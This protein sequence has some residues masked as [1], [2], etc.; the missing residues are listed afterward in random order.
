MSDVTPIINAIDFIEAH[1]QKP[2]TVADVAEAASYSLYH[3]C[4]MFNQAT[5]HTPYDY[6]MRRRLSQAVQDL[7]QTDKKIIDVALEYQFNNPETFSRAFRRMF[8]APPTQ[9]RKEGYIDSRRLRHRLTL[10]HLEHLQKASHLRPTLETRDTFEVVGIM[11]L[12]KSDPNAI[13]EIWDL[14]ARELEKW[15]PASQTT[16]YWGIHYHPQ[17]WET[18]GSLYMVAVETAANVLSGLQVAGAGL[19]VK[20]IPSLDYACFIHQG[21]A[22]SLPLT[23]DYIFQTWLPNSEKQLAYPL[24]IEEFSHLWDWDRADSKTMIYVPIQ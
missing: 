15:P 20:R 9:L 24:V 2:V 1:L 11:T 3:F 16:S 22:R 10:A 13:A 21:P 7:F 4:R 6:L 8:G 23:W 19:V 18:Q 17:G 12:V 5:H 14:F